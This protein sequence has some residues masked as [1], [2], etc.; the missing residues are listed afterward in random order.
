M[1]TIALSRR[2]RAARAGMLFALA[3][4][5][6]A[7]ASCSSKSSSSADITDASADGADASD[8]APPSCGVPTSFAW[9]S[10]GVLLSPV[11]D[12]TH[13]LTAIKDPSVVYFDNKW[14]VFA[15]SVNSAGTYSV[16]YMSFPDWDHTA[17]ATFDYLDT[18]SGL[19]ATKPR[20]RSSTSR[21]RTSGTWSTRPGRPATRPT[22]TSTTRPGGR[23]LQNFYAAEPDTVRINKGTGGWLDF[24]VICDDASCFLFFSDDFGHWYRSQTTIDQFPRVSASR[25]S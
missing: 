15:S 25:P 22:T 20:R 12:A 18:A 10:T 4:A 5:L 13:N 24:W 16:V 21:R 9:N 11:S 14:H 23:R 1:V 6:A 3:L 2:S 7:I 8:V 17:D 19:S